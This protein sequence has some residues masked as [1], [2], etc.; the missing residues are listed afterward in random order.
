MS[1]PVATEDETRPER[2][3]VA[4]IGGGPAGMAAAVAAAGTGLSTV[5]LDEQAAPGGQI[6]RSIEK[7]DE[8][9]DRMRQLLGPDYARGADLVRRFR[10]ST[11][12]YRPRSAVFDLSAEGGIGLVGEGRAQW[13]EARR[14]IIAAGAQERPVPVPGWTLPGVMGLGSAQ[15]ALKSSAMVSDVPTV[16]AGSGPLLYLAAAQLVDAGARI[17]AI[18]DTTP[19]AHYLHAAPHLPRAFLAGPELRKGLHWQRLLKSSGIEFHTAVHDIRIEGERQVSGLR[20]RAG[21]WDLHY[22]CE[23][24]LLHEGVVPNTQLAMVAGAEHRY[25]RLQAS[26]QPVLDPFGRSSLAAVLVAG[27]ACGIRGAD[28]AHAA[29]ELAGLAASADLGALSGDELERR[30]GASRR[31]IARKAPLRRFLDI[32]FRPRDEVLVPPDDATM[33]CRCEEV[34]AGELR[35]I[36]SIGCS[37]P[38]QAK[39]FSRAGMGPCQ[40]RMCSLTVSHLLAAANRRDVAGTGHMRIR[41]PV[42]PVTL[43]ELACMQGLPPP[44]D[45]GPMLPTAPEDEDATA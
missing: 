12:V 3:D 1:E 20:A 10:G 25:S 30:S 7:V 38:N 26:W 8:R 44:P 36:A 14:V 11:A 6:Y 17:E 2:F 19:R 5:L 15:T 23:L 13:I 43:A 27:D 45:S 40:G 21:S 37:G 9:G 4:V 16:I 39:A 28:I 42:K 22:D 18:L 29:G 34:T 33:V 35:Q 31:L 32:L 41:P 24:V